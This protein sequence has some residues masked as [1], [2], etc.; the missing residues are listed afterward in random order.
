MSENK[1]DYPDSL[2]LLPLA[3]LLPRYSSIAEL[4]ALQPSL[5]ARYD[6]LVAIKNSLTEGGVQPGQIQAEEK[7]LNEVLNWIAEQV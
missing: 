6:K 4:S 2:A 5:Y 1:F 7:M 3:T